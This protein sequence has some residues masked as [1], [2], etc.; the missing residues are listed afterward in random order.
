MLPIFVH[1][2]QKTEQYL[3]I[4]IAGCEEEINNFFGERKAGVNPDPL[5]AKENLDWLPVGSGFSIL[6]ME[7]LSLPA[8]LLQQGFI[9]LQN[10]VLM[11]LLYQA[12]FMFA[13]I[14]KKNPLELNV[15]FSSLK[16]S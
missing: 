13:W 2:K 5:P 9:A 4:D 7:Y 10:Y 1:F 8:F 6:N 11:S 3:I 14:K 16:I 12:R 15:L